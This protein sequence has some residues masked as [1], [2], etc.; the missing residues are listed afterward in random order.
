MGEHKHRIKKRNPYRDIHQIS[1]VRISVDDKSR[2]KTMNRRMY[3][4]VK[5]KIYSS[6]DVDDA[7]EAGISTQLR[8]DSREGRDSI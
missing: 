5:S 3:G 2:L 4:K 7:R 6:L 1:N 8:V